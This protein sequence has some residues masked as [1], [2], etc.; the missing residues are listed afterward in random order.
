VVHKCIYLLP[1]ELKVHRVEVLIDLGIFCI[2][3]LRLL[4]KKTLAMNYYRHMRNPNLHIGYYLTREWAG[5]GAA[6]T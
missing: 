2:N 1:T 5:A 4:D 6:L 3:E